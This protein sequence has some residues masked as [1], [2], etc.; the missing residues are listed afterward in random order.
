MAIIDTIHTTPETEFL[1]MFGYS[2][3]LLPD[4]EIMYTTEHKFFMFVEPLTQIGIRLDV[5]YKLGN[6]A[7]FCT[8]PYKMEID[9]EYGGIDICHNKYGMLT[10][11]LYEPRTN[12]V[13]VTPITANWER[14]EMH[15]ADA[16]EIFLKFGHKWIP[17]NNRPNV[18]FIWNYRK[19]HFDYLENGWLC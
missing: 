12:Q 15:I 10:P 1:Q 16:C 2:R 7:W 11:Y 5:R 17:T 18:P 13:T 9:P 14:C 3:I 6:E 8:S 19:L 4:N